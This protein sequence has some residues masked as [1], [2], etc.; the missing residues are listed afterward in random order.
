[1]G[2]HCQ[3]AAQSGSSERQS[4]G[5]VN[6]FWGEKKGGGG[7][8]LQTKNIIGA[9]AYILCLYSLYFVIMTFFIK[10]TVWSTLDYFCR[11][12]YIENV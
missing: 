9:L 5:A 1:M 11:Y 12:F 7:G 6:S 3:T 10:K 4:S 2:T 8:Q